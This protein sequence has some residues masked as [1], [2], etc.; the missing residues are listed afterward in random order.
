MLYTPGVAS[1]FR[2][3]DNN[4]VVVDGTVI[5]EA[6]FSRSM[7]NLP[8]GH[9]YAANANKSVAAALGAPETRT[10]MYP[11][12]QPP[13]IVRTLAA[14]D[15]NMVR[16]ANTG[17]DITAGTADDYTVSLV[18]EPSCAG[19]DIRIR[20]AVPSDMLN[21]ETIASCEG[22][23]ATVTQAMPPVVLRHYILDDFGLPTPFEI[24]V[25][26]TDSTF[27]WNQEEIF[28]DGFETGDTASWN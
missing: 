3:A 27:D 7:L 21:V 20:S 14:D 4:P 6:T 8:A 28:A 16:M 1:T 2:R 5:H 19:V 15:V 26:D 24:L 23:L 13:Q 11:L 25:N 17:I 18:L 9:G 12:L 22:A 10:V